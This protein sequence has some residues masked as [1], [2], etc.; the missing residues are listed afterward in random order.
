MANSA[1]L[2]LSKK[3]EVG[4]ER[5]DERREGVEIVESLNSGDGARSCWV[6]G[7]GVSSAVGA[8]TE[9]ERWRKGDER[10][11]VVDW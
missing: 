6:G 10:R 2:R 1:S 4:D 9:T 11:V 8:R 7:S 5:K 3:V